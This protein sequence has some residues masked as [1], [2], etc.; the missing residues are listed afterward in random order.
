M[1]KISM[2][3]NSTLQNLHKMFK[4]GLWNFSSNDD[5]SINSPIIQTPKQ[6]KLANYFNK[7]NKS[8]VKE[9]DDFLSLVKKAE[10]QEGYI[11]DSIEFKELLEKVKIAD[12]EKLKPSELFIRV[13]DFVVRRK[14][15]HINKLRKKSEGVQKYAQD[16]YPKELEPEIKFEQRKL[17]WV[18]KPEKGE[19]YPNLVSEKITQELENVYKINE[20][21][22]KMERQA[23]LAVEEI[24]KQIA[25]LRQKAEDIKSPFTK[26]QVKLNEQLAEAQDSL[27]VT[28]LEELP[29]GSIQKWHN[30][31]V[32]H[33]EHFNQVTEGRISR[34][35]LAIKLIEEYG[36]KMQEQI[37]NAMNLIVDSSRTV[38]ESLVVYPETQK[39]KEL[40]VFDKKPKTAGIWEKITSAWDYIIDGL[41]NVIAFFKGSDEEISQID[42]QLTEIYQEALAQPEEEVVEEEIPE[43]QP[44]AASLNKQAKVVKLDSGKYQVQSEKGKNLG[45]YSS[46]KEAKERLKDVE[47]FKH[48]KASRKALSN[49]DIDYKEIT[50][51]EWDKLSEHD[52]TSV[53]DGTNYILD[54][55]KEADGTILRPV[56]II[57]EDKK[58]LSNRDIQKKADIQQWF[59]QFQSNLNQILSQNNIDS[60]KEWVRR[61]WEN[62]KGY[63][64][65]WAEK[66]RE[67][68]N[69]LQPP[70]VSQELLSVMANRSNDF[71]R[72]AGGGYPNSV[73]KCRWCVWF[74]VDNTLDGNSGFFG[75]C[76]N[77]IHA[78]TEDELNKLKEEDKAEVKD[79]FQDRATADKVVYMPGFETKKA[80]MIKANIKD[81]INRVTSILKNSPEFDVT[82]SSDY[83]T[84]IIDKDGTVVQFIGNTEPYVF[85]VDN[86]IL[87]VIND[88]TERTYKTINLDET[89][90]SNLK[91]KAMEDIP[92][93]LDFRDID[94]SAVFDSD[95]VE[96]KTLDALDENDWTD[97]LDTMASFGVTVTYNEL[98]N[99]Y[100]VEGFQTVANKQSNLK[101]KA[102]FKKK[103][104]I[105]P[106]PVK[107]FVSQDGDVEINIFE[108]DSKYHV[109]VNV[110]GETVDYKIANG[111]E[112]A[113]ILATRLLDKY[114]SGK[115]ANFKKKADEKTDL[116]RGKKIEKEHTN[117]HKKI[118]KDVKKDKKL[119]MTSDEMAE[120]IAKDHLEEHPD[121][122]DEKKGLPAMEKNLEKDRKALSSKDNLIKKKSDGGGDEATQILYEVTCP[123][124]DK[125]IEISSGEKALSSRVYCDKCKKSFSPDFKDYQP[126]SMKEK[127][128]ELDFEK[129]EDNRQ[130]L[131]KI[132]NTEGVEYKEKKDDKK[133]KK[134]KKD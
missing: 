29:K 94:G 56:R 21:V 113:E 117:V 49:K 69:M 60:A 58:V 41:K 100:E 26:K 59:T 5:L 62:I 19:V 48:K 79:F 64:M 40:A 91:K 88:N 105:R 122:Y 73:D 54:H 68:I 123:Y 70:E 28:G 42:E 81:V 95:T 3:V 76:A 12:R 27:K 85:Y 57:G 24:N 13:D 1:Q 37:E 124:C 107:F 111:I 61:N 132:R 65:E 114:E 9:T 67:Y 84:A 15:K 118:K 119:D 38:A 43:E 121:Y 97:Y 25:E 10:K 7:I 98:D 4:G 129:Q 66:M 115:T 30:M 92:E 17:P 109:D 33:L 20:K 53:I 32:A 74:N 55:D 39:R 78:Y 47:F 52:Y 93:G 75:R 90:E 134:K 103:S 104:D 35:D 63:G 51:E 87:Y 101:K 23:E 126:K 120:D 131:D 89:I 99:T 77:C 83:K 127:L 44:V 36:D 116:E 72:K 86:N 80:K 11:L 71:I 18:P 2:A 106:E 96:Y 50:Q 108:V 45:T 22:E 16:E 6:I 128:Q 133:D 82:T 46:E 125:K 110:G 130:E 34:Q 102:S 31:L 14:A 112:N 8:Y